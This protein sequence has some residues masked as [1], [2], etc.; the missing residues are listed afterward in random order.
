VKVGFVFKICNIAFISRSVFY[1]Y[2]D[3][4][5]APS[6]NKYW[7]KTKSDAWKERAGKSLLLSSDGRNDSPGHCAQYCT[8]S[9]ADLEDK[10]IVNIKVVDGREVDNRKSANMERIGFERGL[11]EMLQSE[12]VVEEIVTDGHTA[13]GALMSKHSII[14]IFRYNVSIVDLLSCNAP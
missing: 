13:I 11:D 2:Q 4:Y 14:K 6:I 7:E 3:L 8:Y 9:F 12:M 1:Q 5:I 10:E